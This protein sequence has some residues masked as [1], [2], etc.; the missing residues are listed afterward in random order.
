MEPRWHRQ[1][2]TT[3][4]KIILFP[5]CN[6]LLTKMV[7][8]NYFKS[9]RN[10]ERISR[11]SNFHL[12]LLLAQSQ[13]MNRNPGAFYSPFHSMWTSTFG[14]SK[15]YSAFPYHQKEEKSEEA[16]PSHSSYPAAQYA[17]D[18]KPQSSDYS[19]SGGAMCFPSAAAGSSR[20]HTEGSA[21]SS[22]STPYPYYSGS[23]LGIGDPYSK[24][25]FSSHSQLRQKSKARS[26][27]GKIK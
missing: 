26:N 1:M 23:S 2:P 16:G 5:I 13:M 18:F 4:D 8:V 12:L 19:S 17:P 27:A 22:N 10:Y 25:S 15:P 11:L 6:I 9:D 14:Q 7:R 20:K 3:R 21:T 24:S